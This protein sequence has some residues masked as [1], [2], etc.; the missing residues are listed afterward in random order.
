MVRAALASD[1]P[2]AALYT[3]SGFSHVGVD[4]ERGLLDGRWTDVRIMER[5]L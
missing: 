2:G 1:A 4:R 5:L 3:R